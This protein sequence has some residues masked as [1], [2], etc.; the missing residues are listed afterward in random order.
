MLAARQKHCTRCYTH[1]ALCLKAS[2]FSLF[3][4]ADTV[5]STTL[6]FS[7][8][9]TQST[10][11]PFDR[12]SCW[13]SRCVPPTSSPSL[14][15]SAHCYPCA[16]RYPSLVSH[17]AVSDNT[18]T[19]PAQVG[20]CQPLAVRFRSLSQCSVFASAAKIHPNNHHRTFPPCLQHQY[21]IVM[22]Q[23]R[24]PMQLSRRL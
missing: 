17:T 10:H 12:S 15:C 1:P 7:S 9:Q 5:C 21:R 22:Q 13:L 4:P 19:S 6:T 3:D 14:Y 24:R 8:V 23:S 11:S 2:H 20:A 16:R 18:S